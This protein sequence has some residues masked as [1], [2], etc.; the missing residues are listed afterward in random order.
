VVSAGH[1]FGL[2]AS[3]DTG[4]VTSAMFKHEAICFR[5]ATPSAARKPD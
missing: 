2:N 4:D 5:M 1:S 3:L